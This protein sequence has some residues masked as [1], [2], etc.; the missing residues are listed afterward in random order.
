MSEITTYPDMNARIVELLRLGGSA[1]E[2]YAATRIEELE[3]QVA[4][5]QKEVEQLEAIESATSALVACWT[6]TTRR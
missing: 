6:R 3:A 1:P 4:N 2:L 5:L